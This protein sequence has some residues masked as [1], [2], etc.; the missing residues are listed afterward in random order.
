MKTDNTRLYYIDSLRILAFGL[1][2]IFHCWRPFDHFGWN[3]KNE[4]QSNFFDLLTVFIH[5]WRMDLIFLISGIGTRFALNSGKSNF[6]IERIKRLVVP[7]VFGIIFVIP[8]QKYIETINYHG[9]NGSYFDFL[10][11]WP[12]VAFSFNFGSSLMLWFGHLGAHIYYL[13]YLFVMTFLLVYLHKLY[14]ILRIKAEYI[15]KI[16]T[17]KY[18]VLT[19]VLPIWISRYL[20]TPVFPMYT[21]WADF[22]SYFWI[23]LY[24]F[25]LIKDENFIRRMKDNMNGFLITGVI[26]SAAG[27]YM[28]YGGGISLF[29]SEQSEFGIAA[30]IK[31]LI[32]ALSAFSWVMFFLG[33]AAKKLNLNSRIS[34]T[35]NSA[36]LPV[37]ILHQTIIIL[38]GYFILPMQLN[39]TAKFIL[40]S[41]VS[42]PLSYAGYLIIRKSSILR[43][44]FGMKPEKPKKIE[45]EK[46]I[47]TFS[48]T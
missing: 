2:F 35:A 47:S 13:P 21:D 46:L 40:L 16:V 18:G 6:L 5:S 19:L 28:F 29:G 25:A 45:S 14:G 4:I 1:L 27:L 22:F 41:A 7:F 37:Y 43:F 12:S 38:A 31:S 10:M 30:G 11:V 9:F 42:I 17:S 3:I 24:G 34:T 8:P 44:M 39:I 48:E 23:F 26:A 36:I 32:T 15:K 33:L 20:L